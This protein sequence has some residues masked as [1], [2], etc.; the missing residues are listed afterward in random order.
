MKYF[1]VT[2][3][4]V[5]FS[6][7]PDLF[8][9]AFASDEIEAY[10]SR[11]AADSASEAAQLF[12]FTNCSGMNI[13]SPFKG[14]MTT[15]ADEVSPEVIRTGA[16]NTIFRNGK[17]LEAFNTDLEGIK[18]AIRKSEFE[19]SGRKCLVLG[20]GYSAVSAMAVLKDAGADVRIANRTA[21]KAK[22]LALRMQC[23][24]VDYKSD[25]IIGAGGYEFLLSTLPAGADV[26]ER[27]KISADAVI[28]DAVYH[29]DGLRS[30]AKEA[31]CKYVGGENWLSG[32]AV[33]AYKYYTGNSVDPELLTNAF[34]K[35]LKAKTGSNINLI[36]FMGC[37]KSTIGRMVAESLSMPFYDTDGEIE[38]ATGSSVSDIF[39]NM[40]EKFFRGAESRVVQDAARKENTVIATGGGTPVGATRRKLLK[41]SGINIWI[42]SSLETCFMGL[43]T[44]SR[45]LLHKKEDSKIRQLF[46][47]RLKYYFIT[48]DLI[49]NGNKTPEKIAEKIV[50]EIIHYRS[51]S[52]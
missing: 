36:G 33:P 28:V 15:F 35:A 31:G 1:A 43:D 29:T 19:P 3:N 4:P 2:G 40:G 34:S 45:P 30:L 9:T 25:F 22:E 5:L 21:E 24:A 52:K 12:N 41:K 13:T 39:E 17:I 7:S 46:N 20:A 16:V 51:A 32:Q 6:K 50:S 26:F 14:E 18:K 48:S 23:K 10:Y 11:I 42:A 37:G 49:V 44:S 8:N 38:K 47:D 27:L